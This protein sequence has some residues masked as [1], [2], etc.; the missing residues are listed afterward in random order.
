MISPPPPPSDLEHYLDRAVL[1]ISSIR[2]LQVELAAAV[3]VI[4]ECFTNQGKLLC[5]GNGGSAAEAA[6][7][8]TEFL[9]RFEQD[10]PSLAALNL[11]ADGSF[12][13]ATGND[14]QFQ[15]IFARQIDGLGRKDDV[16]V[17]FSTSGNSPNV[18]EALKA[19]PTRGLKTIA[20]LGRDGGECK[21]LAEVSLIVPSQITSHIQEAHQVMLHLVCSAVEKRLF[22]GLSTIGA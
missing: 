22:P 4:V 20:F 8:A 10:R 11:S 6:H 1:T 7:L 3:D 5:C 16:L 14:Y 9:C 12:L 19:A 21:E 17:V 15:Q 18:V 13:T 2:S